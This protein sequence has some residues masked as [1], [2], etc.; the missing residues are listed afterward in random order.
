R[1]YVAAWRLPEV[2]PLPQPQPSLPGAYAGVGLDAAG[3]ATSAPRALGHPRAWLSP[4]P[5][6]GYAATIR[7]ADRRSIDLQLL[8]PQGAVIRAPGR[9]VRTRPRLVA[10]P[11]VTLHRP[12]GESTVLWRE[13]QRDAV[14]SWDV[15]VLGTWMRRM[16]ADGRPL[17][18]AVRLLPALAP[19]LK[20]YV[21]AAIGAD[22]TLAL[23]W[24]EQPRLRPKLR[25]F[26]ATGTPLGPAVAIAHGTGTVYALAFGARGDVL[27]LWQAGWYSGSDPPAPIKASLFS[28]R[29]EP[30]AGPTELASGE[31][32]G[33]PRMLCADVAS[34]GSDTNEETWLVAWLASTVPRDGV[35]ILAR[36]FLFDLAGS[37]E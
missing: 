18:E 2:W 27:V 36:R 4:R 32:A 30:R 13:V 34:A 6:G 10:V 37:R 3:A 20:R 33:H 22:G 9:V 23:V 26:T 19:G 8:S 21:W 15:S 5:T 31:S 12:D 17:G 25:T 7:S 1:G 16:S 14:P 24:A 35:Q 29:G 28:R 11:E